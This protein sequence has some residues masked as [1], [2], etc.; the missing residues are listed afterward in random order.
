MVEDATLRDLR[1]KQLL[2]RYR[3]RGDRAAYDELVHR[4]TPMVRS[5]A[6]KYAG[7][8]EELEDLVQVGML[9]LV[10][11][12]EGFDLSRPHRF[13]AYAA[14]TITGEMKRHFR[15]HC[16]SVAVPRSM[17]ELQTRVTAEEAVIERGGDVATTAELAR[18]LETTEEQVVDARRAARCF[19]IDS[20]S[21]PSGEDR[22]LL[23]TFGRPEKGYGHVEDVD[24][25][26]DALAVLSERDRKVVDMRYRD[27]MLQ[28]E[29]G[30][31]V[32]VSQMQISRILENAAAQMRAHLEPG[33]DRAVAA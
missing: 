2:G 15:D 22:E 29:I 21:F 16:W 11:A 19:R 23:D 25:L 12:I 1:D 3:D 28:R 30:A 10:K 7:R 18:R 6:R 26:D 14:P 33:A 31:E 20:L 9:G 24:L 27:E 5:F 4:F 32:N 8:G 17:K 13:V